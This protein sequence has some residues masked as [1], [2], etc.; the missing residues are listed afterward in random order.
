[1]IILATNNPHK[2]RE[3][4]EILLDHAPVPAFVFGEMPDPDETGT[5]LEENARIKH[6]AFRTRLLEIGVPLDSWVVAEDSGFFVDALNGA[7]GIYAARWAG[8]HDDA[9]NNRKLIRELHKRGL[10]SSPAS[11][12][13][14]L[15]FSRLDSPHTSYIEGIL[16]VIAK[17][18]PAGS[19]GFGYDPYTYVGDRSLAQMTADEKNR[20][21]SRS[22]AL[23]AMVEEIRWFSR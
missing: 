2:L 3:M 22:A 17:D 13:T 6:D 19:E 15:V 12:R 7:P 16:D 9:S 4:R 20:I 10:T 11:Y 8:D 18:T 21:S 14:G 23:R 1:M 5:S